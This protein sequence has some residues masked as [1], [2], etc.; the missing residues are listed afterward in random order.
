MLNVLVF[1][2]GIPEIKQVVELCKE[3]EEFNKI[4]DDLHFRIEEFH[5]ALRPDEKNDVLNPTSSLDTVVRIILSTKI[6]ET[7]VTINNIMYVLDSGKE[8]EYYHE[9]ISSLSYL[10][11]EAISKSSAIQRQGRAGRVCSGYCYKMYTEQDYAEFEDSKKP[12]LI[13]MDISEIILL[14]IELQ[15]HFIMADLLFYDKISTKIQT[16]NMMLQ[17]KGCVEVDAAITTQRLS[18]K[19]KFVVESDLEPTSAMFL[20]ECLSLDNAY[21]GSIA[22]LVLEKPAG[23][24]KNRDTLAKIQELMGIE[25]EASKQLGDLAPII[26]ILEK[27]EGLSSDMKR[28]WEKDMGI[29]QTDIK[30]MNRDLKKIVQ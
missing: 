6:A 27:Y 14:S 1:L 23:Y 11:V 4:Q 29:L 15:D 17:R 19:G 9:E 28:K 26:Y 30:R 22:T 18:S 13:R 7:A 8:R 16:L 5:G 2:P 24:F 25:K 12:E 3:D 20:Y 10:K 21:Y